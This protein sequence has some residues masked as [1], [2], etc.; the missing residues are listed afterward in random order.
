MTKYI[1]N[2]PFVGKEKEIAFE[3]FC[4]KCGKQTRHYW[5]NPYDM[6][7]KS[8]FYYRLFMLQS[9]HHICL[10]QLLHTLQ[11]W[12]KKEKAVE[13]AACEGC[14]QI[15]VKCLH[16]GNIGVFK[17]WQEIYI[18]PECKMKSYMFALHPA[19]VPWFYIDNIEKLFQK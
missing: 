2:I 3:S 15:R 17:Q 1:G 13:V 7:L 9:G 19:P 10:I 6:T 14:G 5:V 18:C 4:E 12:L 11:L 8:T 16:C